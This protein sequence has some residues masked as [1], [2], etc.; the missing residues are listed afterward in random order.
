LTYKDKLFQEIFKFVLLIIPYFE[1]KDIYSQ[2]KYGFKYMKPEAF[3][4]TY[5]MAIT[6]KLYA[7][8][9]RLWG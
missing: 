2:Q 7:F 9:F 6:N 4:C 8:Q 5:T 1:R 3:A